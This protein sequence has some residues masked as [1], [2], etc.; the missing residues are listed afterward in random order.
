M[1]TL[2]MIITLSLSVSAFG[3]DVHHMHK[4]KIEADSTTTANPASTGAKVLV[5][6]DKKFYLPGEEIKLRAL[7]FAADATQLQISISEQFTDDQGNVVST[8]YYPC[9]CGD[10]NAGY[11]PTL[12]NFNF[13]T[14]LSKRVPQLAIGRYD[15]TVTISQFPGNGAASLPYQTTQLTVFGMIS[16]APEVNP[17]V[18]NQIQQGV[19]QG[20]I[21]LVTGRFPKN[22]PMN[23]FIGAAP[24]EG[25]F[26]DQP[27]AI[28]TDG[29]SLI[30]PGLSGSRMESR[31]ILM[32]PDGSF[33]TTSAQNFLPAI[34]H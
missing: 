32:L 4:G 21:I 27:T 1:K 22:V 7:G 11:V 17:I 10:S 2:S 5:W 15:F 16:N 31:V 28:S 14:L 33:S 29:T 3:A 26:S 30:L 34:T 8:N 12:A 24:Y 20:P 23:Y 19:S 25:S 6:S 18:I 13:I 9:E